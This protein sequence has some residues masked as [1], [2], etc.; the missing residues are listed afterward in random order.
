MELGN[1]SDK[2]LQHKNVENIGQFWANWF[3]NNIFAIKYINSFCI[4]KN[5]DVFVKNAHVK[6]WF[7]VDKFS[8]STVLPNPPNFAACHVFTFYLIATIWRH[9]QE[10]NL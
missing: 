10:T 7:L 9:F 1:E 4:L 2:L 3:V 5:L 8:L 6:M